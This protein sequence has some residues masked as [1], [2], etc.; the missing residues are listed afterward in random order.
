VG[1]VQAAGLGWHRVA[2]LIVE[3][4]RRDHQIATVFHPDA[5]GDVLE[6]KLGNVRV[7]QGSASYQLT[8]GEIVSL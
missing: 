6:T 5:E 2:Q 7:S 8:T 1:S 3:R 4:N